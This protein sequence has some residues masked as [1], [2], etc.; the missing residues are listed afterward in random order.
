MNTLHTLLTTTALVVGLGLGVAE[1]RPGGHG[2]GHGGGPGF[3]PEM[4]ERAAERIGL[5]DATLRQVKDK[6]YQ[7]QKELIPLQAQ[8]EALQLEKRHAMDAERPDRARIFGIIEQSNKLHMDLEKRR[9]GLM[10]DIHAL[11]T[12]EQVA[13]LKKM[14]HEFRKEWRKHK[15]A[16]KYGRGPGGAGGPPSAE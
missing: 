14:R 1:A 11:L 5:D 15:K 9:V 16:S 10:L 2:R 13:Q 7:A 6:V 8:L 3:H 12:P 4:L